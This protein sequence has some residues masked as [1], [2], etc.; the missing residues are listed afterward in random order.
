MGGVKLEKNGS[1]KD[2]YSALKR[3]VKHG[4]SKDRYSALK[5]EVKHEYTANVSGNAKY[6]GEARFECKFNDEMRAACKYFAEARF[7]K[8]A[9]GFRRF[10]ARKTSCRR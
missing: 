1:S 7:S 6:D 9:S 8:Y 2:R 4:S 3:E 5:R 10:A